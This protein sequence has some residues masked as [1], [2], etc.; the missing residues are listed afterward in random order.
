MGGAQSPELGNTAPMQEKVIP[1]VGSSLIDDDLLLSL[2][3]PQ[4][5][6]LA[7]TFMRIARLLSAHERAGDMLDPGQ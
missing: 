2:I 1:T 3:S 6:E 7:A 4:A 5:E